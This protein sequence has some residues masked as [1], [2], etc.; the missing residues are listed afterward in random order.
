MKV[1]ITAAAGLAVA[2]GASADYSFNFAGPAS[3]PNGASQVIW[4]GNLSGMA[5]GFNFSFLYGETP[6]DSSWA[7]DMQIT[8]LAPNGNSVTIGGYT[9]PG[10]IT[11]SYDGGISN[12]PGVYGD[13][14]DIAAFNLAGSGLWGVT[15][16]NDGPAA[17]DPSPNTIANFA[18]TFIGSVVPTPGAL[19][20]FGIAGL[21]A[22]RRRR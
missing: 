20:L 12:E 13:M 9:N 19:G 11:P 18:G 8:L 16:T 7:S 1:A 15:I 5:T 6:S 4:S 17:F 14:V 2:A 22:A 3:F 10:D 21:A